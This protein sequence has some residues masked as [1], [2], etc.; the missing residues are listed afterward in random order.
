[1]SIFSATIIQ[2]HGRG[3]SLGFP[4]LNLKPLS[5]FEI[6]PGVY[7]VKV[8]WAGLSHFAV[9][10]VGPRPT[11]EGAEASMEVHVL[12]LSLDTP[13]DH[14][15]VE[16]FERLRPVQK[17]DS[18]EALVTQIQADNRAARLIFEKML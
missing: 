9:M 4:T 10:H 17:F 5:S 11:F 1:M 6:E 7:A 18:P 2:G 16:V 13:P 3:K 15:N 8:A 14:L 12:D